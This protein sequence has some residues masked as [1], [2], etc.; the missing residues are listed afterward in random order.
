M[1]KKEKG[2]IKGKEK[3]ERNERKERKGRKKEK[4]QGEEDKLL[5]R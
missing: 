1:D 2:K 3:N 4:G 5:E